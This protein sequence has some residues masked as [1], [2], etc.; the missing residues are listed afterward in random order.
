ML[1]SSGTPVGRNDSQVG[2]GGLP[3]SIWIYIDAYPVVLEEVGLMSWMLGR[4][5]RAWKAERGARITN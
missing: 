5:G 1:K 3:V 2:K 4:K